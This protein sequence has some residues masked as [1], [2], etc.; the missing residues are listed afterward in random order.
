MQAGAQAMADRYTYLPSI[1]IGIML[2]WGI[3]YLLPKEK[4][5]KIIFVPVAIILASLTFLTWQQC[6]YW[7][8]S[9]DLFNHTLQVTKD[10][11]L[12]HTNLGVALAAEGKI[13]E[14]VSHYRSALQV[15]PH[16]DTTH[17][18]LAMAFKEQGNIEESLKHFQETLLIN[19]NFPDAHNNIGIILEKYFKKY[20]E[21]IYHYEQE[22]R[23]NNNPGTHFNL[24][25]TLAIKGN[26]KEASE[27]FRTA[28]YLKPDYEEAR[29]ALKLA[30]EMD[31]QKR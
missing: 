31:Q 19:P 11:Y 28:I 12:A 20:D 13:E 1:G 6:G 8:N 14:A 16:D 7:K 24:G 26:L 29:R 5:R 2:A 22:L 27:H 15:K 10:N 25:I 30:L 9:I 21:A 23:I 18:N 3:V 4:L 17:Y